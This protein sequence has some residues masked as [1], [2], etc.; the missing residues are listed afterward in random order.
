MPMPD[1]KSRD[2]DNKPTKKE[3]LGYIIYEI[4]E[5]GLYALLGIVAGL[6][7]NMAIKALI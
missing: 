1:E 6:V 5:Y 7:A 3:I 2:K 4:Y